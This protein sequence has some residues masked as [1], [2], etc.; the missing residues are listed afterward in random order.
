MANH[1][2]PA[3]VL[4]CE[5]N[6]DGTIGGSHYCLLYLVENLDKRQFEPIVFFY[7]NHALVERFRQKAEVLVCDPDRPVR[8]GAARNGLMTLGL[9]IVLAR[10]CVNAVKLVG[11]IAN[12]VSFLKRRKIRL[13]HLNNSITRHL[14]WIVACRIAGIPCVVHERGLNARYTFVQ[15]R[16]ARGLALIIPMSEWIKNHM[17]Q[18]GV[19]ADNIRVMYDGLEPDS[20]RPS[21]PK[22]ALRKAWGV[23]PDQT[24]IG[25][26]GNIREWKGQETV[27]RAIADV[28]KVRPD[29][30]CFFVGAASRAD[31][32]FYN[33]LQRLVEENHIEENVRFTGYQADVPSLMNMM[34]FVIHASVQPE[35]FGMV[36]LEAMAQRKAVLG[37]RAGGVIEM[38]LEGET[39]YTFPPG[40]H[41]S[42]A[43]RI[44]ELLQSP[45]RCREMG[46]R[47]Y[48]RLTSSF[49]LTKYVADIHATYRSILG[50]EADHQVA[51]TSAVSASIES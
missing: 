20:V 41:Q 49:T 40:D 32:E 33:R 15:R 30:V 29:V 1:S 18:R 37:A 43:N 5:S 14:D 44:I 50:M 47:G 23:A 34:E 25:M 35:P 42:L 7:D 13:V 31:E 19:K 26:V 9:P 21:V 28:A 45:A 39:G 27:I 12:H 48:N 16:L 10:R 8:W 46:E 24:V 36:V 4:Y 17:V 22:E 3:R 38:V 11:T 2:R 6:I 51:A